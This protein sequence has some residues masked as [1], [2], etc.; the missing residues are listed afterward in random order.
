LRAGGG[1]VLRDV[2]GAQAEL[3]GGVLHG[4]DAHLGVA[5][6]LWVEVDA[7]CVAG[8][9]AR[10][11]VQG[12]GRA[13]QHAQVFAQGRVDFGQFGEV[14]AR[15]AQAGQDAVAVVVEQRGGGLGAGQ[16]IGG[17][18]QAAVF[19]QQGQ[20]AFRGEGQGGQFVD[21]PGEAFA[22]GFLFAGVGLGILAARAGVL[23][24]AECAGGVGGKLAGAG[25]GIEQA[26]LF[27]TFQQG[28]VGML[29]VDIDQ[30]LARRL[31]LLDGGSAAVDE[32]ARAAAGFDHAAQQQ[33][34]LLPRQIVL[35]QQGDQFGQAVEREL[36]RHFRALRAFAHHAG[37][38]ALAQDQGKGIEQDRLA[39]AGLA[40]EHGKSG[41]E[42][43]VEA[44]D[45]D[46]VSE[47][48]GEQ[49]VR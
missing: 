28:V 33:H 35:V 24:G 9:F 39:G 34:A 30:V 47:G 27:G 16:E 45:Q 25:I 12:V 17:M 43:Q 23:P 8:E 1:E 18:R 26:A 3:S 11:L 42:V 22:L 7:L 44:I 31:E 5:Q 46:E 41:M 14:A 21:R 10:G 20:P 38:G 6:G 36:G 40:G 13:F 19:F 4:G 2:F 15:V 49:H 48:Q 29:A 32:G 37:L